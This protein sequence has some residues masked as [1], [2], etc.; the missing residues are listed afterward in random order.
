MFVDTT[1]DTKFWTDLKPTLSFD[2]KKFRTIF[3]ANQTSTPT[4]IYITS[5]NT[6]LW[7]KLGFPNGEY[8]W[9]AQHTSVNPPS[10]IPLN[11]IYIQIDGLMN[12]TG[13][14]LNID[15][16]TN[17]P[18]TVEVITFNNV[19]LGDIFIWRPSNI[20]EYPLKTAPYINRMNIKLLNSLGQPA[21]LD[22]DYRLQIDFIY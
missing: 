8:T 3:T 7:F 13:K 5:T 1:A 12:E 16:P 22:A 2:D 21:R 6:N 15:N 9:Q 11:E 19:S 17:N 14:L 20:P 10:I 4:S 18:K